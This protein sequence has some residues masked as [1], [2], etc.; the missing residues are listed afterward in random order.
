MRIL[1]VFI[2]SSLILVALPALGIYLHTGSVERYLEFPPVTMYVEHAGE[3]WFVFTILLLALAVVLWPLVKRFLVAVPVSEN[4]V[5]SGKH[6]PWWGWLALFSC[7]ASWILAWTRFH[8]FQPLQPYTFI[9]LWFSFVILVNAAAMWRNG[10]SLLTKTPGQF[11]LLFPASSLFWWYF[12]YLNRFVQNWY[13]VGIEDFSSL[14]YVLTASVS[15][16][17][18]LPAVLSMNHLLKSWKRFDAAYENFFSFTIN[19]PRLF[20]GIFLIFSCG[21]LFSIGIFPDLLFPLLWLAP[22]IIVTC[23]NALLGLPTVFYNLRSGSWTGICRLAFSSL[24]CGFFWEMWNY[25][26]YA[27]WIYCIPFV[28]QLKVFE[29]PVLG[30]S[31][32]LPFGLECA[33]AGSFI[34]S[35][36]DILESGTSRTVLADFSRA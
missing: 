3:S 5:N 15:F 22:L 30:Y 14:N 18:V 17:T 12:E 34:M 21:G 26:S 19:R 27:K 6:F 8:W 31:G 28:S 10:T 2:F 4:Q 13:Y 29:M 7:I 23:L 1:F 20:A 25:Y 11:L 33:V 35:L 32:Y 36:Q 9:P 16:S 24:L